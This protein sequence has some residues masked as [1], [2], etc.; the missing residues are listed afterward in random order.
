MVFL[1]SNGNPKTQIFTFYLFIVREA[2]HMC[3]TDEWR[4]EDNRMTG[5]IRL[6][7]QVPDLLSHPDS[8]RNRGFLVTYW[9]C[10][11]LILV[12]QEADA[13]IR[14]CRKA[15][16][17]T[18]S[19]SLFECIAGWTLSVCGSILVFC[20]DKGRQ[21]AYECCDVLGWGGV[22]KFVLCSSPSHIQSLADNHQWPGHKPGGGF[23]RLW[24]VAGD[25]WGVF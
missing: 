17:V 6:G 4:S 23:K 10:Y 8:P 11:I 15:S 7:L 12:L 18:L 19:M 22:P 24:L 3:Q 9:K 16:E 14:L 1:H 13:M 5:V 20:A 2:T 25:L 21:L